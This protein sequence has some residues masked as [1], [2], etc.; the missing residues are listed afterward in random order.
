M[1]INILRALCADLV[2]RSISQQKNRLLLGAFAILRKATISFVMSVCLSVSTKQL[3]SHWTDFHETRYVGSFQKLVEKTQVS[4]KSDKNKWYFTWRPIHIFY[5]NPQI[6][7]YN[8]KCFRKK[9]DKIETHILCSKTPF[10]FWK[11]CRL[12]DNV[13]KVGKATQAKDG[14]LAHKHCMLD[15]WRYRSTFR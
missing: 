14:D 2:V 5:Y 9:A 12:W 8:E 11:S 13:G 4:L 1:T 15:N 7:S 3:G 10:F 6:S